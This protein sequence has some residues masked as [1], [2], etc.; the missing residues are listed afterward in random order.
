MRM[1]LAIAI[2]F[3]CTTMVNAQQE[4]FGRKDSS[5]MQSLYSKVTPN[6]LVNFYK[7]NY[8]S[9]AD[10]S[11]Y[12][13]KWP[14]VSLPKF[15][16]KRPIQISSGNV[17]YVYD[18]RS[19]I[20]T[21]YVDRN[22]SQHSLI[23]Q[24]NATLFN[25]A[26]IKVSFFIRR[27]NSALFSDIND[28]RIDF[29][30]TAYARM[31]KGNYL[32]QLQKQFP[33]IK[34]SLLQQLKKI[35][36]SELS[37][38]MK[39]INDPDFQQKLVEC[40]EIIRIPSIAESIAGPA[41]A[42]SVRQMAKDFM[43]T[44]FALKGKE[45]FYYH[46]I[47]SLQGLINASVVKAKMIHDALG[48]TSN[49]S[50]SPDQAIAMLREQGVSIPDAVRHLLALRRFSIG[51][52]QLNY[53]ELTSR[54][55]SINGINIEYNSWYY[56]AFSAGVVD[57]RFRDFALNKN[58]KRPQYMYMVRAGIGRL[59]KNFIILSAYR[60]Q[61]Q[62]YLQNNGAAGSSMLTIYGMSLQSKYQLNRNS[63][64]I[65]EVAQSAT[66]GV[67]IYQGQ[68]TYSLFNWKN[69]TSKAYAVKLYSY[70]PKTNTRLEG[71]Y[72]YNGAA[73]QSFDRFQSNAAREMW[74]AKAEQYFWK[75]Q[76]KLSASL[77]NDEFSNPYIIVPYVSNGVSKSAQVTFRRK[78]WPILSIGYMPYSQLS[79]TGSQ[80]YE[81]RFQA[82]NAVAYY[83]YKIGGSRTSTTITYN[84]F[85]NNPIDTAF[86]YFNS[87][88]I[89]AQQ[90]FYFRK[91]ILSVGGSH[92]SNTGY[93][94]NTLEE[95][96]QLDVTR[97]GSVAT[98]LKIFN[99]NK[100]ET[101]IGSWCRLSY[102]FMTTGTLQISYDNGL[103][104]GS[105]QTLSRNQI[106][107][108]ILTK[109]F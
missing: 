64:L 93:E 78:R 8:L 54:N 52:S 7:K 107:S 47:D 24:F 22:V 9:L 12:R 76:I 85:Y 81:N 69:N 70:F 97:K 38:I 21:P 36:G 46:K 28:V 90:Y 19:N 66:P 105:H 42:D 100:T 1:L 57:Y 72:R 17:N 79:T 71:M 88:N 61:K 55:L 11:R 43:N 50:L 94:L 23:G 27:T 95:S 77:R 16:A 80:V 37:K 3:M 63:Y 25:A 83:G 101:K 65:G 108:V 26:P 2:F 99:Y 13:I 48:N 68:K 35:N 30:A 14:A 51:R 33:A 10:T 29:D 73:F 106:A 53:S 102:R 20:D 58:D 109:M 49:T 15:S 31:I 56:F 91:F 98:G 18:Y 40:N 104:P 67:E 103:L 6:D 82:L 5:V 4:L 84:R 34:D 92:S 87:V 89:Y 62:S 41:K 86:I 96:I 44:Y 75:R 45:D 59:E 74:Y 60:G 39:R 32:N